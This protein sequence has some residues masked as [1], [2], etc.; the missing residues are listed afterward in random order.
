MHLLIFR[1]TK[2]LASYIPEHCNYFV[3]LITALQQSDT[4][5]TMVL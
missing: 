3:K 4:H 1:W 2:S 5:R